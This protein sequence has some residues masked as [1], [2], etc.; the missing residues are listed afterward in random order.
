M[1]LRGQVPEDRLAFDPEIEKTARRNRGKNKKKQGKTREESSCISITSQSKNMENQRPAP[2]RKTLGDYAMQQ[3]PGYFSSI[4]IPPTTKTLEMKP[5]FLSLIS[6]HQFT[7][8]DNELIG[9]MGFQEGD[10]EHVYM[11]LFPF[12]LVGK[13]K[14]WL[15]SHPNQSLNSWKDVQEKFLN[16]FFPPSRYIKAKA[17]ISTFRQGPD[18][19]FC[20]AWERFNSL[21]R[22]CPN[23]GFEDIAQLNIF[24]NGLRP[25]TKM[26]L[27]TT[28]GGTMMIVDVEQAT[29]IIEALASTDHQAQHNRQTI[30]RKGVLDLSTTDATLA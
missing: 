14:E 18:E 3:G 22:K 17:D 30:Q 12:S 1:L 6:S 7:G 28:A 11:R 8:M 15:K 21:L 10:L 4:A 26:I 13:A 24:Y 27:D 16:I 5:V 25:D 20:E 9:T 2:A 29:R 23:H 19:P